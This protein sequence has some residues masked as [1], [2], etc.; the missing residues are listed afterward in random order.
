[1]FLSAK[2]MYNRDQKYYF[3][4]YTI[5]NYNISLDIFYLILFNIKGMFSCGSINHFHIVTLYYSIYI[6]IQCLDNVYITSLMLQYSN[7]FYVKRNY[8]II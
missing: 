3:L 1:M 6:A 5:S 4:D 7:N 8:D 2:N